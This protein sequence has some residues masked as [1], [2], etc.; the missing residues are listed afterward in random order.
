M[1]FKN[2]H[3]LVFSEAII[4]VQESKSAHL[5]STQ[6][7]IEETKYECLRFNFFTC[8]PFSREKEER[9]VELQLDKFFSYFKTSG[10]RIEEI[11]KV[12]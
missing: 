4:F 6:N 10:K 7:Y 2:L 3:L 12:K 5:E 8:L 9:R 11:V 1:A